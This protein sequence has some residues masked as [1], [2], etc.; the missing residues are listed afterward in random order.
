MNPIEAA[1]VTH[2]IANRAIFPGLNPNRPKLKILWSASL[3]RTTRSNYPHN[4][5]V[6]GPV[7]LRER[8]A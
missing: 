5:P 8:L 7:H 1:I 2:T 3:R 6:P 4:Y